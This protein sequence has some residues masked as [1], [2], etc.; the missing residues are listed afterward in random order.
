MASPWVKRGY[1]SHGHYD[2]AS[3]Y[4]LVAHVFGIPYHNDNIR[5]AMV[6]FDAF[7]STPDYTPWTHLP[8]KVAAP[9]NEKGTKHAREAEKW[10]FDDLDD[11]PG[12]SQHIME[13]MRQPRQQRG[14]RVLP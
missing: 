6:P 3:V 7:T 9:C 1:V 10:D 13:M 11:Q 12:L 2:M 4:K 14:I 8:R 5:N